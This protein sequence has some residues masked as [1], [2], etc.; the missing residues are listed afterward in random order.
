[1]R[2]QN[3]APETARQTNNVPS[4]KIR[5][6]LNVNRNQAEV[7]EGGNAVQV[8]CGRWWWSVKVGAWGGYVM[9]AK[10]VEAVGG[11]WW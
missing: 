7:V 5:E 9:G 4:R 1:M 10:G 2:P 6:Q 8:P 11:R 3:A